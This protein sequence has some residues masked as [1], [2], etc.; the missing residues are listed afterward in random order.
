M[1]V[2]FKEPIAADGGVNTPKFI[3]ELVPPPATNI[4][5]E[6]L[7]QLH[8]IFHASLKLGLAVVI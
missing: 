4:C 5:G 3:L 1:P 7:L 8:N 2:T 6:P